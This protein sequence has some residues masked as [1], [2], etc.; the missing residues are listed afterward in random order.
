MA[1]KKIIEE[2]VVTKELQPDDIIEIEA[3]VPNVEYYNSKSGNR[4]S[5]SETGQVE[6]MP[7]EDFLD[8]WRNHRGYIN[9]LVLRPKDK[10]VIEKYNLKKV[11]DNYDFILNSKNYTVSNLNKIFEILDKSANSVKINVLSKIKSMVADNEV[12]NINVVKS[13][14]KHYDTVLVQV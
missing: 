1:R 12:T 14:E 10:R 8:I 11:Y 6:Q 13:I 9:D 4:Y 7:Y 5:W 3:I 2:T